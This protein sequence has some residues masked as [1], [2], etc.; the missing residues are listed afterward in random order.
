MKFAMLP[1]SVLALGLVV[2]AGIARATDH[3]IAP[4][5]RPAA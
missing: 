4:A 3:W 5:C 1:T 2:G